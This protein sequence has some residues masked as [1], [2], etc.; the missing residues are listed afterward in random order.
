MDG[1]DTDSVSDTTATDETGGETSSPTGGT[2]GP[3][4][5][6]GVQLAVNR[7]VDIL[8]VLDNS[9]SMGE[10]QGLLSEKIASFVNLLE[11]PQIDANYRIGV[12]TSDNG[13]P[14]CDT[15]PEQ[16][17]LVLS[18]CR[19]RLDDFMYDDPGLDDIGGLACTDHC[20]E[21]WSSIAVVETTTLDDP[22]PRPRPW[23]ERREGQTNLPEGLD[24]V[25]A[26][27][28]LV[29]Q[30]INGC[31]FESPLESMFK[32]L[33]RS[34]KAPTA[35]DEAGFVR[36]G[37]VLAMLFVTDEADCS[38]NHPF[39][40]I[41]L[42]DGMKTFWSL[43]DERSPTSAVCWNAGVACTGGPGTYDAC[44]SVDLDPSG[45]P[46]NDPEAAVLRP[47]SRYVELLQAIEDQKRQLDPDQ[48]VVVAAIAGVPTHFRGTGEVVY[49]DAPNGTPND[50]NFQ[51]NFGIGP[52]CT[53][54]VAE[55]VPPVRL[56]EVAEAFAVEDL[57][58]LSS[59]CATDYTIA[60]EQFASQ[61]AD[62][63]RY[64]CMPVCVADTNTVMN[65]VQPQCVVTQVTGDEGNEQ[66][67]DVP[68][69][70]GGEISEGAE[71][72]YVLQTDD[73][74]TSKSTP[75]PSD[76][77]HDSCVDEGWNLAF[78]IVRPA[79]AHAPD[80]TRIQA[81]CVP[82]NN[83]PMDCPALP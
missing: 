6:Q 46:V 49:Q 68:P 37:A 47:V 79:D 2:S 38:Y 8:L 60:L 10:E 7:D 41:F 65:G 3:D 70:T 51:T 64:G 17:N 14:W 32:T 23:V 15:T 22:T 43:P 80:D 30:G 50:P 24:S 16:G 72:C 57:A 58:S 1:T 21:Q 29:P 71:L 27:Q 56:R 28:C 20:P 9:G 76:D 4:G 39:E 75:D 67:L 45:A 13:N 66:E 52:G 77:M 18:S 36:D 61:I 81:D 25:T 83:V 82:S 26:L 12:T 53:S 42:P 48:E 59:V 54:Q 31:G 74:S 35:E 44:H 5:S 34:A 69:C 73:G 33:T 11:L 40:S 62:Q 19:S 63:L 78:R 55:A